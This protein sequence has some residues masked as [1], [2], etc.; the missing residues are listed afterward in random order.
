MK[1]PARRSFYIGE[2]VTDDIFFV[3]PFCFCM[4]SIAFPLTYFEL[5]LG[6]YTQTSILA[7]FDNIAPI[8]FGIGLSA[9]FLVVISVVISNDL[10]ALMVAVLV[11]SYEVFGI[12]ILWDNCIGPLSRERYQL[13]IF[14]DTKFGKLKFQKR[15]KRKVEVDS[16]TLKIPLAY[17]YLFITSLLT[18]TLLAFAVFMSP[19]SYPSTETFYRVDLSIDVWL[20]AALM[21]C[22]IMQLGYG[23]IIF[24]GSQN[25]F[26]NDIATDS[27]IIVTATTVVFTCQASLYALIRDSFFFESAHGDTPYFREDC[28]LLQISLETNVM[29]AAAAI[30]ILCELLVVCGAYGSRR[31]LANISTMAAGHRGELTYGQYFIQEAVLLLWS[32][33]IPVVL[34]ATIIRNFMS[35]EVNF[36]RGDVVALVV[37]LSPIPV[38]AFYRCWTFYHYNLN[39]RRLFTPEPELWGPRLTYHRIL[40]ER[41]EKRLRV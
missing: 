10:L 21:S 15:Y 33:V 34:V 39:W 8:G 18:I 38:C 25:T 16:K 19:P 13:F 27:M 7:I 30:L 32:I 2:N 31:L 40:A 1:R 6:Q 41:D 26:F 35:D 5:A 12:G 20:E 36:D 28:Y 3:I 11:N 29:T 22:V 4:Y 14:Y 9:L 23:G 17:A 24:L 37:I